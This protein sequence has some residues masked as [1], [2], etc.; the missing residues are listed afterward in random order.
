MTGV[1]PVS[2]TDVL[3]AL[4]TYKLKLSRV[5][6]TVKKDIEK[7]H[8][9]RHVPACVPSFPRTRESRAQSGN[10]LPLP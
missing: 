10:T 3:Q 9:V 5:A 7:C 1:H 6:N 4:R 2:G 8:T